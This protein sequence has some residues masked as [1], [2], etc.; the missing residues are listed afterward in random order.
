[1]S[2]APAVAY[3][4]VSLATQTESGWPSQSW[5]A[6]EYPSRTICEAQ[7]RAYMAH[8]AKPDTVAHHKREKIT[9]KIPPRCSSQPPQFFIV[10]GGQS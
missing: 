1:M 4:I 8:L 5:T 9:I 10:D 7:V 6:I 2:P 3:F